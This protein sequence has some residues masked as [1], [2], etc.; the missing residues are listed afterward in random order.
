MAKKNSFCQQVQSARQTQTAQSTQ[1]ASPA[2]EPAMRRWPHPVVTTSP[3]EDAT[4]HYIY[5]ALSYQN[6]L[7]ADIKVLLE[8]MANQV[9]GG[10]SATGSNPYCKKQQDLNSCTSDKF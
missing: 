6:Q 1:A 9:A 5:C 4:L 8:R 2:A 7:L 3:Q 10:T